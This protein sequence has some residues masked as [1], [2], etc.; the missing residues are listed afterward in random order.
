MK[1]LFGSDL[2]LKGISGAPGERLLDRL[3]W[4]E[5]KNRISLVWFW[6]RRSSLSRYL[7]AIEQ[8]GTCSQTREESEPQCSPRRRFAVR[9][10][11][12]HGRYKSEL[13]L[14]LALGAEAIEAK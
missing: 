14:I 5:A 4:L 1:E 7:R 9:S 13:V 3:A 2:D 12:S 6:E 11:G 8:R 10:N